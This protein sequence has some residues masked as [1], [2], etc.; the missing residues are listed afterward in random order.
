MVVRGSPAPEWPFR[1]L[2]EVD[3]NPGEGGGP[4]THT[5]RYLSS[6]DRKVTEMVV[7]GLEPFPCSASIDS[8]SEA[9]VAIETM[10]NPSNGARGYG[11]LIIPWGET[12]QMVAQRPYTEGNTWWQDLLTPTYDLAHGYVIGGTAFDVSIHANGLRLQAGDAAASY[13]YETWGSGHADSDG[14]P[15]PEN[16]HLYGDRMAT[17]DGVHFLG[18]DGEF[19]GFAA[20]PWE[21]NCAPSTGYL[22]SMRTGEAFACGFAADGIALV[23][24]PEEGLLVEEVALPDN[25]QLRDACGTGDLAERWAALPR[26]SAPYLPRPGPT[27]PPLPTAPAPQW[28]FRGAVLALQRYVPQLFSYETVLQY[29]SSEDGSVTELAFGPMRR[30][31]QDLVIEADEHGV[32][33]WSRDW[34]GR[35]WAVRVHWGDVAELVDVQSATVRPARTTTYPTLMTFGWRETSIEIES[36]IAREQISRLTVGPHWAGGQRSWY[37]WSAPEESMTNASLEISGRLSGLPVWLRGTDGRVMA[38]SRQ[39][40]SEM[41][42]FSC[43]P[44]LTV[45]ISLETGQVLSC[46]VELDGANALAFVAPAGSS[47]TPDVKLPPSGW[48]DPD[49]CLSQATDDAHHCSLVWMYEM[50]QYGSAQNCGRL[51]ELVAPDGT[52]VALVPARVQADLERL[53]LLIQPAA[54]E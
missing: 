9:G 28:P 49:P 40:L 7:E 36:F 35:E 3:Y 52:G 12:P 17:L 24:P 41:C 43:D 14:S 39:D 16:V 21:P 5:I 42:A 25:R 45:L 20:Y 44:V 32:E 15:P 31:S 47:M 51:F 19:V 23:Q 54:G 4:S 18:T 2:V 29:R 48:L 37:V 50:W 33:V 30:R 10:W 38:I 27:A 1:G 8:V 53:E 22:V 11:T 13:Q 6:L 34:D 26:A 46:G